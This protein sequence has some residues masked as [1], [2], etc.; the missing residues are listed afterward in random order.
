MS[1]EREKSILENEVA[2]LKSRVDKHD[3]EIQKIKEEVNDQKANQVETKVYISQILTMVEEIKTQIAL[4]RDRS[5]TSRE[6]GS[7]QWIGF[8]QSFLFLLL[9]ALFSYILTMLSK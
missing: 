5:D 7:N 1:E 6:K 9:G 8:L 4:L 2:H 3:D